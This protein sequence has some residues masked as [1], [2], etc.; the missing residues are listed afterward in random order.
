M[1]RHFFCAAKYFLGLIELGRN[2]SA[3]K[4]YGELYTSAWSV[5]SVTITVFML[6][7]YCQ[8]VLKKETV[9]TVKVFLCGS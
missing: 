6:L 7:H 2:A 4:M 9:K 5:V 1:E 3:E 8:H